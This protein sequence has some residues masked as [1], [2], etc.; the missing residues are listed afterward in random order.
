MLVWIQNAFA[1]VNGLRFLC[2][3]RALFTGP[4][5]TDFSKFFFKIGSHGT[6]HTFKNYF[7]TV[8][9][10]FNFQFSAISSI[11]ID[12][13]IYMKTKYMHTYVVRIFLNATK[14]R[15]LVYT[16][17]MLMWLQQPTWNFF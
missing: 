1:F 16:H 6:I 12:P 11:Q 3:S 8:F 7:S 13:K 5:S 17:S 2:G 15:Y 10:I 4:A 9:S 14:L